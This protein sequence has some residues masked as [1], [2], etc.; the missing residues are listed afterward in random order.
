MKILLV[1]P[2]FPET[3]WSFKHALKFITKKANSPPLGLL[4]VAALIPSEWEQRLVDLNVTALRD[5]DLDWADY[6]FISAMTVQR[7]STA[8]IIRR[9]NERRV[10]LVAGGP[11]FTETYEDFSAVNHL[12]L[13]EAEITLPLFLDDLAQGCPKP[14]YKSDQWADIAR[15]P[16]P[17]WDL[18]DMGQYASMDLQYSRGCPFNCDFCD[19][20]ALYGRLPRTK[21]K[22][23]FLKELESL[24]RL[25]WRGS[26]FMVDDNFIGNR[27]KLEEEILPA[28]H[29]WQ[30]QRRFPFRF[31]TQT[32]IDLSDDEALMRQ[33][34]EAGFQM[35]FVGIET[36]CEESLSECRKVQNKNRDLVACV[37]RMQRNG[38]QVQGGFIVG[39]DHD[40]P[41]IFERQ[42]EF[43]QKSGIVTAM[44]GIL[45][46]VKGTE[47]YHR[48]SR[49]RRILEGE[50]G[51]NTD[52]TVN[53]IPKMPY[54]QLVS[55]YRKIIRTIY[56]PRF[57]YQRIREF[58]GEF[59]PFPLPGSAVRFDDVK[60][61]LKSVVIIGVLGKER[62][63][64]WELLLWSLVKK[65]RLLP[66]A[67]TYA[68]YGFHFRKVFDKL[69]ETRS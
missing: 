66:M 8:H 28:I 19:I 39:F 62:I 42:I 52:G 61:L 17:R 20:T 41:S 11:L 32:S 67:V 63:Y 51:N 65:P 33:M 21:E 25:G 2:E 44:V 7:E 13:N 3:F 38:L 24:Y 27:R 54:Q 53:F 6:V 47:L 40:P 58:M 45:S 10:K 26:V 56:T 43:I 46:A 15:T 59:S 9:C 35:V 55:G 50:T 68:I 57:Y 12:V 37:K 16:I 29:G 48:L 34:V 30:S 49:E 22:D 31:Y 64:Y 69:I 36:P 5:R 60:A 1:Y 14:I 4:T 18:V 23:Q